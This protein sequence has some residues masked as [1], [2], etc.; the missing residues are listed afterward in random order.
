MDYTINDF[1][2][3]KLGSFYHHDKTV[4]RVF[5]PYYKQLC[6]VVDGEE[7]LMHK[8]GMCFEIALQGDLENARYHYKNENGLTFKGWYIDRACSKPYKR[9]LISEDVT[10]YG[11]FE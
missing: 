5:A 4:F 11:L 2:I 1:N 10:I 3:N 6:V 9:N 7:Y 8:N